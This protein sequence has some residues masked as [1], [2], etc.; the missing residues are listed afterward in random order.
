MIQSKINSSAATDTRNRISDVVPYSGICTVC[1]DGCTGRCEI[2]KTTFRGRE[3]LYPGPYGQ[4]TA[5]ATKTYPVDFSCFNIQGTCV[6]AVGVEADSDKATF[7]KVDVST[8]L[9]ARH[10]IKLKENM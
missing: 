10:K 9:G 2:W 3:V 1:L 4:V 5:G 7:P 8:E 6:G